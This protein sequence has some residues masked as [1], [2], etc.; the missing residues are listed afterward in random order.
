ML[1]ASKNERYPLRKV[2][3]QDLLES[4]KTLLVLWFCVVLSALATVWMVHLTRDLNT[5]NGRLTV[6]KQLLEN[7]YVNLKLEESTLD[8]DVR[9]INDAKAMHLVY[10]EASQTTL[11]DTQ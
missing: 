11:L 5:E 10:P 6:E 1:K 4:N 7:E 8:S 2:I 3:I 9:V